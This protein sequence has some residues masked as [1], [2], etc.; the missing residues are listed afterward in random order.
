MHTE[1]VSPHPNSKVAILLCTYNGET[2]LSKLLDS[3]ASQ[4]SPHWV[5]HASDDKS[6]DKTLDILSQ[7]QQQI[8][9]QRFVIYTGPTQGYVANFL[10]LTCN[11]QIQADYYAY[12]DQDDIWE[13]EK[14]QRA[15]ELLNKVPQ[16]IPALYCSRTRLVDADANYIGDSPLFRKKPA[17][18][19]ALVQNIGGGNTMVVNNA[20]RALLYKASQKIHV[21][22]HDWWFYLVISGCG[23]TVFYDPH[24]SLQYRQHGNNLVGANNSWRARFVRIRMMFKGNFKHWNTLNTQALLAI[25]HQLTPQNQIILQ[26]FAVSRE[27]GFFRRIFG[28]LHSGIYRQTRL[29]NLGLVAATLFNKI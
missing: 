26:R 1:V 25:A 8:G 21:I 14:L 29:G 13:P 3:L 20:A 6:Q 4:T 7:Y 28:I 9:L 15:L 10:S 12:C 2:Y 5:I 22:S 27:K 23:G 24:P 11:P 18:A 17:F 19:N 16:H